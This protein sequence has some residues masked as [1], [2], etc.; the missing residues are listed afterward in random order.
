AVNGP[1]DRCRAETVT[2]RTR[3]GEEGDAAPEDAEG[4][5]VIADRRKGAL[6]RAREHGPPACPDRPVDAVV[7]RACCDA[8]V[9]EHP[10]VAASTAEHRRAESFGDRL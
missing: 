6:E 9:E 10:D 4:T 8:V 2:R 7:L 1:D 3:A 5:C